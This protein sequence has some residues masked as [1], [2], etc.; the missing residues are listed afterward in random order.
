MSRR[1]ASMNR[2]KDYHRNPYRPKK[3]TW[4]C[5]GCKRIHDRW[6]GVVPYSDGRCWICHQEDQL[7]GK[8]RD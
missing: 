8:E 4:R 6:R 5:T 3:G 7:R 2:K 1:L